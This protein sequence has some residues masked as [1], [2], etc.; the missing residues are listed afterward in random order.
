MST[1]N[2]SDDRRS[3]PRVPLDQ[4][5]YIQRNFEG[6]ELSLLVENLSA[7][8]AMLICPELHER[9]HAGQDFGEC[10]LVLPG[11]GHVAVKLEIRW[12]MWPKVGV[13]FTN[14]SK[15][16]RQQIHQFLNAVAKLSQKQSITVR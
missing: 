4:A 6:L 14:V 11:V 2:R 13:E 10:V 15:Q 1:Q 7:A 3:A 8:G 16:S 12:A 5:V 9:F